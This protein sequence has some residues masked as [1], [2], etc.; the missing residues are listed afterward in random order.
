MERTLVI[1]KPSIPDEEFWDNVVISRDYFKKIFERII[2]MK[3]FKVIEKKEE[4]ISIETAKDHYD[5]KKEHPLFNSV[6]VY[7][8]SGVSEILSI[9]WDNSIFEVRKISISMRDKY[10]WNRSKLYNMIHA[11]DSI[12]E[13]ER[14]HKIHFNK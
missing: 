3:W 4:E 12:H 2:R 8:T 6:I 1:L 9:S 11:S 13:S 14:E 7:I 5:E 10:I